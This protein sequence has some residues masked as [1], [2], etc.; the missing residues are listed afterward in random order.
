M[1]KLLLLLLSVLILA[2][3][4][5]C[6]DSSVVI[7]GTGGEITL[8]DISIVPPDTTDAKPLPFPDW[9]PIPPVPENGSFSVTASYDYGVHKEGYAT[10]LYNGYVPFFDLPEDLDAPLAGDVYQVTFEGSAD[11]TQSYPGNVNI[12]GN[13]A[14]VTVET[15]IVVRVVYSNYEGEE[16]IE[17]Y[18]DNG[19]REIAKV[20]WRP[21]Y[22]VQGAGGDGRIEPLSDIRYDQFYATYSPVD[23]Y[24]EIEGYRFAAFYS[25]CPR[26]V[27][28]TAHPDTLAAVKDLNENTDL[29]LDLLAV[30]G[31]CDLTEFEG[32]KQFGCYCYEKD[33]REYT[34]TPYPDH[35]NGG[36][37]LTSVTGEAGR[38]TAFGLCGDE[39]DEIIMATMTNN[40]YKLLD[41]VSA[42]ST[43]YLTFLRNGVQI[44]F[45]GREGERSVAIELFVSNDKDYI[46]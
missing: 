19:D 33:G 46:H 40:G 2:P 18:H 3:L 39:S 9:Y 26:Y 14:A 37:Y 25:H 24:S 6:D 8:P 21:D 22:I 1:K 36:W 20:A 35:D 27:Q 32:G 7:P 16:T 29:S 41:W 31:S 13:I 34:F 15:A 44:S 4:T 45:S 28:R 38:I 11:F 30:M 43:G 5:G 10:L 42:P 12:N 17:I 23:G